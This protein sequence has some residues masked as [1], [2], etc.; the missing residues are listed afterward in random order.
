MRNIIVK[1][2]Y[3]IC[4]VLKYDKPFVLRFKYEQKNLILILSI[5]CKIFLFFIV[6]TRSVNIT[7]VYFSFFCDEI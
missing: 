5:C 6:W 2:D 3:N 7:T 4:K 1:Y